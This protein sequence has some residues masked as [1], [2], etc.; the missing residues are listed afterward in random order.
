MQLL[1]LTG[2]LCNEKGAASRTQENSICSWPIRGGHAQSISATCLFIYDFP[3]PVNQ[4]T[5]METITA[6]PILPASWQQPAESACVS[7][8]DY[9]LWDYGSESDRWV[10]LGGPS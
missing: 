8:S 7:S 2:N 4:R 3:A 10:V 9:W 1:L 5:A 6:P